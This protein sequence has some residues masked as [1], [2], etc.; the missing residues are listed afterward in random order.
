MR[1][2]KE[3]I[4]DWLDN[5]VNMKWLQ[6]TQNVAT[7]IFNVLNYK[8]RWRLSWL[9]DIKRSGN[10]ISEDVDNISADEIE[11]MDIANVW[12]ILFYKWYTYDKKIS[13][14]KGI[15]GSFD[16]SDMYK[17]LISSKISD[18][19][20][21]EIFGKLKELNFDQKLL[22]LTDKKIPA[23]IKQKL[24]ES[25]NMADIRIII[26]QG[27]SKKL[28]QLLTNNMLPNVTEFIDKIP[29]SLWLDHVRPI[30]YEKWIWVQVRE[31]IVNRMNAVTLKEVTDLLISW[32]IDDRSKFIIYS[33]ILDIDNISYEQAI[34]LLRSKHLLKQIKYDIYFKDRLW[35]SR[36][37]ISQDM[38]MELLWEK[39]I[40]QDIK[41]DLITKLDDLDDIFIQRKDSLLRLMLENN[42]ENIAITIAQRLS[43]YLDPIDI[44]RYL[45]NK[46]ISNS[47]KKIMIKKLKSDLDFEAIRRLFI[48]GFA[49][50]LLS[51]LD[52]DN[53]I[54]ILSKINKVNN[55]Y[56]D[57]S[58]LISI[59]R[60]FKVEH[61]E[62]LRVIW[63]FWDLSD[64]VLFDVLSDSLVLDSYK[65]RLTEKQTRS[66]KIKDS[67]KFILNRHIPIRSKEMII[68]LIDDI[69]IDNVMSLLKMKK[70]SQLVK[71][72]LVRKL[73]DNINNIDYKGLLGLIKAKKIEESVIVELFKKLDIKWSK[74]QVSEIMGLWIPINSDIIL[75]LFGETDWNRWIKEPF[76]Q[77]ALSNLVRKN[78]IN[79][80]YLIV[81]TNITQSAKLSLINR[82]HNLRLSDNKWIL[83]DDWIDLV[84]R[85]AIAE[86]ITN[87]DFKD[88][89]WLIK[90]RKFSKRP[91]SPEIE[92]I[93]IRNISDELNFSQI[94]KLLMSDSI[95]I[96]VRLELCKK[97]WKLSVLFDRWE[98]SEKKMN[99]IKKSTLD[100]SLKAE[101][102]GTV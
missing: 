84:L 9:I 22:L 96:S 30:F 19:I 1:N 15:S 93:L 99:K 13:I 63:L 54:E 79:M 43:D 37:N 6:K 14:I 72:F 91:L 73:P 101:L 97:I 86:K 59:I 77:S 21:D 78:N 4:E 44:V 80:Q 48:S 52:E 82:L 62:V 8:V 3:L 94:E 92:C 87:I 100:D 98:I 50:E 74:D 35:F 71:W 18:A 20:K 29:N 102:F 60:F 55:N 89:V 36:S 11:H 2:V 26:L 61:D 75:A 42:K 70:I 64:N 46:K 88:I 34:I 7:D 51:T 95:D 67:K 41:D 39:G 90:I 38:V 5:I 66:R 53:K 83:Q 12:P 31:Q 76:K 33:R 32:K 68:N 47:V 10:L 40:D 25:L 16:L 69:S 17:Y 65:T 81:D 28:F 57:I 24:V 49:D 85:I 56:N 45:Y 27:K 23:T 58:T